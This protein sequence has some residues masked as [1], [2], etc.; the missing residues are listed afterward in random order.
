LRGQGVEN[1]IKANCPTCTLN[2]LKVTISELVQPGPP[3]YTSFLATHP[4]GQVTDTIAQA[5]AFALSNSKT[6]ASEGRNEIAMGGWD[7]DKAN[8][9]A[10]VTGKPRID[11]SVAHPY[12]YEAWAAADAIGRLQAGAPLPQ[13]LQEMPLTLVTKA[14]AP[15]LLKGN[16]LPSTYPAPPGNWQGT[17]EKLWGK[18]S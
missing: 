14:N 7:G 11:W 17:F 12:D 4:Q 13:G 3:P 16:P 6:D 9:V 5:D 1:V 2:T 10:M 15:E 8:L 18:A